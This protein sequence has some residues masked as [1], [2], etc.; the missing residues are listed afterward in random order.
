[1]NTKLRQSKSYFSDDEEED[2]ETNSKSQ[3]IKLEEI[4]EDVGPREIYVT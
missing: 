1:M 3:T 2:E 4:I